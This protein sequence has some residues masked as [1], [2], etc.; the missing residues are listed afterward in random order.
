MAQ[1]FEFVSVFAIGWIPYHRKLEEVVPPNA[2]HQYGSGGRKHR[3][4]DL[5]FYSG[6]QVPDPFGFQGFQ[7]FKE[8]LRSKNYRGALALQNVR[9]HCLDDGTY[10][11]SNETLDLGGQEPIGYTPFRFLPKRR[12]FVFWY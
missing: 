12:D 4:C 2:Y 5:L 6:N 9:L 8:F 11:V 7:D 10:R 1:S 3:A